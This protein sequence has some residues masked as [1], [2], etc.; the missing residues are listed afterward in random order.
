MEENHAK[1]SR[2]GNDC[3]PD[4]HIALFQ[5]PYCIALKCDGLAGLSDPSVK[6]GFS[7]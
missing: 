1:V 7:G 5:P 6:P 2:N 4:S 3:I